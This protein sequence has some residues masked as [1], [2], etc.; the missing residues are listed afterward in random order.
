MVENSDEMMK[1]GF[2]LVTK[3]ALSSNELEKIRP[4][5]IISANN[6][7]KNQNINENK[8]PRKRYALFTFS[9][10]S[11]PPNKYAKN[12]CAIRA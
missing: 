3:P 10:K 11:C 9:V 8:I 1:T 4:E 5:H 6:R 7:L 12:I 2:D